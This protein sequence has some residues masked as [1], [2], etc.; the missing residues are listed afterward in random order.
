MTRADYVKLSP[1]ISQ[2][3]FAL[4]KSFHDSPVGKELFAL[5]DLRASQLNGCL[6]CVDMHSKE[7][8]LYGDR[9]LRLHHL[10]VWRESSL[11]TPKEKAALEYTE[12]LT[13]MDGLPYTDSEYSKLSEHFSEREIAD[14]ALR[15]GMINVWNR[16]GVTFQPT[17]G[18]LDRAYGLDRAKLE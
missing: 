9:E 17:P 2:A 12:R 4:S 5:V 8:R 16:L 1:T 18:S 15:V 11:F 13:R 6:F 3:L 10:S 7:A 14:L